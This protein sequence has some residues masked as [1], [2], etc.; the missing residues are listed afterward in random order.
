MSGWVAFLPLLVPSVLL[1]LL[2]AAVRCDAL[3]GSGSGT[4]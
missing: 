4:R 2:F 1:P 3:T